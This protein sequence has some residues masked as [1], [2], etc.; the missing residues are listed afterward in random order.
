MLVINMINMKKMF[1]L[2]IVV[3]TLFNILNDKNIYAT[4]ND[5][6][7]TNIEVIQQNSFNVETKVMFEKTGLYLSVNND[8]SDYSIEVNYGVSN[9]KIG[10]IID[11]ANLGS[12]EFTDDNVNGKLLITDN[13][14]NINGNDN[15]LCFV[16]INL[17]GKVGINTEV[18]VNFNLEQVKIVNFCR[19]K[20]INDGDEVGLRDGIAGLQYLVGLKDENQINV[21]NMASIF[22][23]D[24]INYFKPSVKNVIVL[25]QYLVGLRDENFQIK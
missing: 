14:D 22:P 3:L 18:K 20:I 13:G 19:G 25:I 4:E 2:L 7:V 16:P 12:F 11:I 8:I 10:E 5:F 24:T 21:V 9:I 17:I 1:L 15:G 6:R 23:Y